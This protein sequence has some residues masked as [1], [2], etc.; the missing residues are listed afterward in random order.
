MA[1]S[2]P[3]LSSFLKLTIVRIKDANQEVTAPAYG[4]VVI[5]LIMVMMVIIII[6]IITGRTYYYRAYRVMI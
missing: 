3:L 5:I 1:L 6:I 2:L 4:F